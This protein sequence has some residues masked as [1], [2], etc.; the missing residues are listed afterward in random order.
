[1]FEIAKVSS[2]AFAIKGYDLIAD[3]IIRRYEKGGI[4]VLSPPKKLKDEIEKALSLASQGNQ[5]ALDS[6]ERAFNELTEN[7]RL[8]GDHAR[9]LYGEIK[10][11]IALTAKVSELYPALVGRI[12]YSFEKIFLGAIADKI[13]EKGFSSLYIHTGSECGITFREQLTPELLLNASLNK[14]RRFVEALQGNRETIHLVGSFTASDSYGKIIRAPRGSADLIA[15]LLA[16]TTD[17]K[18]LTVWTGSQG[19]MSAD[20]TIVQSAKRIEVMSYREA[21]ELFSINPE[22]F[23]PMALEILKMKNIEL[24]FRTADMPDEEGTQ[25]RSQSPVLSNVVKAVAYRSDLAIVTITGTELRSVIPLLINEVLRNSIK[26]HTI[27]QSSSGSEINL[28]VD[29][30]DV[31]KLR[32][33]IEI[34][35]MG[36]TIEDYKI[37]SGVCLVSIIGEGMK[38][39]P[40][41]AARLFGAVARNMINII[42]II[43]GSS[44]LNIG[45]VIR[46][47]DCVNAI[48]AVHSEFIR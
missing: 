28:I 47:E 16:A 21:M 42:M 7:G 3:L 48:R 39:T 36:E 46:G 22:L 12:Y 19:L 14:C 18:T 32:N 33:I 9:D 24:S 4:I 40:G 45:F 15:S 37:V 27:I 1:M 8:G 17:A 5:G 11:I 2:S 38:G 23:N 6:A 34:Q 29:Q 41:V 20:P 25:I 13:R 31:N 10:E 26:Y 44:E 43:Q 35:F 30:K